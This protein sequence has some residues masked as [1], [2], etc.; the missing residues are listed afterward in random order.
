[1]SGRS[2]SRFC[3]AP[4]KVLI[5]FDQRKND[6]AGLVFFF[7]N[8]YTPRTLRA[9]CSQSKF[10]IY[11]K[12]SRVHYFCLYNLYKD[13]CPLIGWIAF[14]ILTI[15]RIGWQYTNNE[16]LWVQWYKYF[17]EVKDEMFHS[18]RRRRVEWNISSFTEWKY[19]FHCTNEKTFIICFI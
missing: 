9:C 18:T 17:H 16:C 12:V 2:L 15:Y 6:A 5:C 8:S 11:V 4:H 19:L 1:M 14:I 10:R 7:T 3:S 13:S